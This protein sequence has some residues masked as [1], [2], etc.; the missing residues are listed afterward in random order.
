MRSELELE[1]GLLGQSEML[2]V[3]CD[4]SPVGYIGR[5]EPRN[6][7]ARGPSSFLPSFLPSVIV[8]YLEAYS[9]NGSVNKPD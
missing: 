2:R 6:A 7:L 1:V 4:R 3:R 5:R 9:T 8:Y